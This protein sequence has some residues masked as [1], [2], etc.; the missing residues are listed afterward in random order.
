MINTS[1]YIVHIKIQTKITLGIEQIFALC[2]S[3]L[4]RLQQL[5]FCINFYMRNTLIHIHVHT[6]M[7]PSDNDVTLLDQVEHDDARRVGRGFSN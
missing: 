6:C 4:K 3:E 7:G 5:S 2:L 1:P